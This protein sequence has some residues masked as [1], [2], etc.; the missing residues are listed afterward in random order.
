MRS[1]EPSI[2]V[3]SNAWRLYQYQ[4]VANLKRNC[5]EYL[6]SPPNHNRKTN[7]YDYKMLILDVFWRTCGK[8]YSK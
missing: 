3:A 6:W 8:T 5:L 7:D 1:K 2:G 4:M